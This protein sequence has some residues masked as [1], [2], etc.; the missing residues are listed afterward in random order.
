MP[1]PQALP[2]TVATDAD[3]RPVPAGRAGAGPAG[4]REAGTGAGRREAGRARKRRAILDAA[5]TEFVRHGLQGA[6]M[7]AIADRAGLPK[8]NVHYYFGSKEKLYRALLGEI[9]HVWNDFLADITVDDDPAE[10]LERFIRQKIRLA[11]DEP[12]ASRLFAQE[13]IQG[14]PHLKAHLGG[15]LRA[16][17]RDK[18]RVIDGWVAAGRMDPVD[19]ALLI[20]M[21]WS[22]TQ[23]YADFEAQVLILTNRREYEDDMI[24]QVGDFLSRVILKGCGVRP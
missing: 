12:E 7:Q 6:S 2:R 23:H 21:I 16:W 11:R 13:I 10:V 17:L 14:A 5:R 9:L 24:E 18:S 15:E 1:R 4:D 22:T 19:P 3:A 8:A 20:F